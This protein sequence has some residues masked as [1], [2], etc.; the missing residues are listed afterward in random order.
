MSS[1]VARKLMGVAEKSSL[2]QRFAHSGVNPSKR[3][4][5]FDY[6]INLNGKN[7]TKVRLVML[8]RELDLCMSV[9]VLER[10]HCQYWMHCLVSIALGA[11]CTP[12]AH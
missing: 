4:A 7:T 11:A 3:F 8:E 10:L 2:R 9:C 5:R 1:G 6:E 12:M